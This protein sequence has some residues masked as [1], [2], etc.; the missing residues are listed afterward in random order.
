[1]GTQQKT[2]EALLDQ[3]APLDLRARKMF[4]EYALYLGEKLVA[5]VADEQLFVKPTVAGG[6]FLDA[7]H[8]APPYPGAKSCLLVP[9]ARWGERVWLTAL[10]NATEAELPLPPPKKPKKAKA[11]KGGARR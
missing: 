2:V 4:G 1:M 11:P 3:L 7:T 9:D 8:L 6:K 10:L 5:L